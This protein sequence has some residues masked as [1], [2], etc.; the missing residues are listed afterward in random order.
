MTQ[1]A[2]AFIERRTSQTCIRN[3]WCTIVQSVL[4]VWRLD[5]SDKSAK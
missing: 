3:C 1:T 2:T 4:Q 5:L